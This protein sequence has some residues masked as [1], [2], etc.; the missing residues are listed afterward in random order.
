MNVCSKLASNSS[1]T[2]C[3]QRCDA[4]FVFELIQ[5]NDTALIIEC[6]LI[7]SIIASC[8]AIIDSCHITGDTRFDDKFVA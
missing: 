7:K 5:P 4:K 8:I 2:L 1:T 6:S 3:L